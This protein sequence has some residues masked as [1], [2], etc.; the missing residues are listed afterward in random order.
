MESSLLLQ[1]F[2]MIRRLVRDRS[3]I[4]LGD[5]KSYLIEHRL[6]PL[7]QKSGCRTM[8]ELVTRL[9]A[10]AWS[11]LHRQV[12]E[13]MTTNETYFFRD[14]QPFEAL[15]QVVVPPLMKAR[16]AEKRINLWCAASS[17]GQEPYSIL[18]QLRDRFPSLLS[19]QVRMIATDINAEVLI[20]A[21]AG[22]YNQY[23]VN[24]GLPAG[25]LNRFFTKD[26][27]DYLV[28]GDLRQ[29]I[30]F[31]V[32]NLI[33]PWPMLPM[34]DVVFLRNVL[35]Y[36]DTDTKKMILGK[37][38]KILRPDGFLFLGG[39]ETTLNID[40]RFERV[41]FDRAGCYRVRAIAQ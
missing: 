26:Q 25:F 16:E 12:V 10:S 21:R 15:A 29:A 33:D 24:R 27:N 9:R 3:G 31:Q 18:M 14:G 30:E 2:E 7:C 5:D 41:P 32:L 35:I 38:F 1:D 8:A 22:R 23:E 6:L 39:A 20:K 13:L 19:W 4:V 17:T 34:M 11:D 37:V 28:N 36:F 40:D